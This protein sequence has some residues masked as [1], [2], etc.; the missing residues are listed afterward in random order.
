MLVAGTRTPWAVWESRSSVTGNGPSLSVGSDTWT[1]ANVGDGPTPGAASTSSP[2]ATGPGISLS[3]DF[4]VGFF[5]YVSTDNIGGG[6]MPVGRFILDDG[7]TRYRFQTK[8]LLNVE[9]TAYCGVPI[10]ANNAGGESA[11]PYD[12]LSQIG[13]SLLVADAYNHFAVSY[14]AATGKFSFFHNGAEIGTPTAPT[15]THTTAGA[16]VIVTPNGDGIDGKMSQFVVVN[17]AYTADEWAYI[18]NNG[19]GRNYTSWGASTVTGSGPQISGTIGDYSVV[20]G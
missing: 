19:A 9:S 12:V 18:Y 11:N 16:R 8:M 3:A 15:L 14:S 7:T 1:A 20:E 5:N 2:L 4:S 6:Q 13:T 10:V 17:V